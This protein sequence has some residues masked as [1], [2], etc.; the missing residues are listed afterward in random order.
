M[1]KEYLTEPLIICK[2][3][4]NYNI[5]VVS[6]DK[7][8]LGADADALIY[9]VQADDDRLYFVK[10]K[11]G[12]HD[13]CATLQLL[14]SNAGIKEIISP[15][16]TLAERPTLYIDE[17]TLTVYP[18]IEGQDGFSKRL[19]DDQWIELGKALRH[20]HEFQLPAL[21]ASHIKQESYSLHWRET[22]RSIYENIELVKPYD[23][24]VSDFLSDLQKYKSV[25]MRLVER[26][27]ELA[28]IIQKQSVD[29]VLCH[30]DLHAGNVFLAK[31]SKLYI[32]DWDQPIQAPK[33][34]DLMF[35]GAG[36]G[37]V[38]NNNREVELFYTGYGKTEINQEIIAYYRCERI[39]RD[40]AEYHQ[41]LLSDNTG[42]K[43]RPTSYNHF[44]AMFV[45]NG[46]VDI[47]LK[48]ELYL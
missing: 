37:N 47:A 40:I 24:I 34:R 45:P 36:I 31:S 8:E 20:L 12:H 44:V 43:D 26:A 38:W 10:L 18:F 33:E 9:K 2:L 21:I 16:A 41:Q 11:R 5:D 6:I 27:E 22:V 19:T 25:I 32:I 7:L 46:V 3:K 28:L 4:S 39:I 15:I 1:E 13:I 29:N 30:G 17:F 23:K 48:A 42:C 14:L 35:I